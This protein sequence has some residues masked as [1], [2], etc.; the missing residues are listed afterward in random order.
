M[1][2]LMVR[3]IILTIY[4]VKKQEEHHLYEIEELEEL[5]KNKIEVR[6]NIFG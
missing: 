6:M 5:E 2:Y 3:I 1:H 4:I